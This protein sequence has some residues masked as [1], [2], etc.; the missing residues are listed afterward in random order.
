VAKSTITHVTDDIDGSPNAEI[1]T[2]ALQGVDY[3]IDL[4]QKNLDKLTK[5]LSP[6][7]GKATRQRA[8]GSRPAPKTNGRSDRGYE[9][10]ALREWAAKKKI[11]LPQR[12]RIPGAIV[13]QY[14]AA[15]SK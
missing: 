2:F 7:I 8:N 4:S 15:S 12:G 14:L 11:S 3:T 6:F 1:V 9:I 5:A 13:Q 10:A